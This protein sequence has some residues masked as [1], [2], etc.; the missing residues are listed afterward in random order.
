MVTKDKITYGSL[1]IYMYK[2]TRKATKEDNK[3]GRGEQQNYKSDGQNK[4][5]YSQSF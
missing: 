2:I 4:N 1:N 5:D 3:R